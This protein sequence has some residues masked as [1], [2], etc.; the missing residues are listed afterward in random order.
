MFPLLRSLRRWKP[1]NFSN[2]NFVRIP[3]CHKIDE[4]TLPDYLASRYYPARIGQVLGE[5]YQIVGKLGFGSTSTAWLA[6]DME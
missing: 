1:L 6:R 4:E 3:E 2:A 5:R